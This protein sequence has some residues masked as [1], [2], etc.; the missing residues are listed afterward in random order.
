MIA[1]A[2]TL[3][4]ACV[5]NEAE[6]LPYFLE[7][8]RQMGVDHFLVVDN[9]SDDGGAELLLAQPDVSLWRSTASY[10]KSRFGID[11]INHLLACHGSGHWCL[12][13][14]AD[15]LFVYAHSETRSLKDLTRWLDAQ[16]VDSLGALMLELYPKGPLGDGDYAAGD[17]PL[18]VV[19][20]F[21]PDGYR[22]QVQPRTG[23]MWVQGGP[24]D[25][26][27]FAGMP[28]RAPTLNKVPLVRWHW[29]YAYVNS[30]H[31]LFPN[32]LNAVG[33]PA[34]GLILHTK[35]LPSSVDRAVTEQ[36]RGEHFGVPGHYAEYYA[37]LASNPTLY[38]DRSLAYEGWRQA[39][40]LGL[41]SRGGWD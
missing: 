29:R 4:F 2:D 38:H 13:L 22:W 19:P 6:R 35:F 17:D 32:R 37:G 23:A 26:V 8:H 25:R 36:A 1:P 24:R 41:M 31:S 14:D 16:G 9:A 18:V 21:D 7:Y 30:T 40:A 27:F 20:F 12:T 10:R 28:D 34:S 15:E 11:W 5:R 33:A 39:E 3:L